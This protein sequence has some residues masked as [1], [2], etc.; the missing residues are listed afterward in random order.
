MIGLGVVRQ[1]RAPVLVDQPVFLDAFDVGGQ[2]QGDNVRRLLSG[3]HESG[4][5]GRAAVRLANADG[6]SR[7]LFIASGEYRIEMLIKLPSGIVG[8]VQ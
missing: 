7:L 3:S 1:S 4:L 6:F 2:A 8:D 5:M